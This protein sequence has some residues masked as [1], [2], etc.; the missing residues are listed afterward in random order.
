MWFVAGTTAG[1]YS[2]VKARR[3][4]YRLSPSGVSDQ[5]GALGEGLRAFAHEVRAGMA[6]REAQIADELGL[7]PP[8]LEQTLRSGDTPAGTEQ[9]D[10]P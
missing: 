8:A 7:T 4:A 1:I 2:T 9:K 10:H 5:A 3:I 6:E